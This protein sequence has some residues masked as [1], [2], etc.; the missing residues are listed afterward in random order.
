M[1]VSDDR[2]HVRRRDRPIVVCVNVWILRGVGAEEQTM[3][4]QRE[5]NGVHS[6][7]A[8]DVADEWRR[9]GCRFRGPRRRE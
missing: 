3:N 4:H 1:E 5:I 7:I 9:R 6:A 8:I 2:N